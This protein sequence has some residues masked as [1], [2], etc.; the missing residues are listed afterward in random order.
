[1]RRLLALAAGLAVLA[2]S[3]CSVPA[4]PRSGAPRAEPAGPVTLPAPTGRS[5]PPP[6]T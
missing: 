1:M 5:A 4:P 2:A 6:C 3:A